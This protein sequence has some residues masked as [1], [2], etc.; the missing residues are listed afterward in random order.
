MTKL[1]KL[2]KRLIKK[3]IIISIV[4]FLILLFSLGAILGFWLISSDIRKMVYNIDIKKKKK[5]D[6]GYIFR[7]ILYGIILFV[8][9]LISEEA[10]LPS[11]IGIF[12][13]KIVPFFE[14]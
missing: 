11:I 12:N 8:P 14:K 10:I 4:E 6:K 2:L 5:L 7:Y 1:K 13:L 3:T 9:A